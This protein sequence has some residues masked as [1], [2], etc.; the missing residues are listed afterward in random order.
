MVGQGLGAFEVRR[1]LREQ[2]GR[3]VNLFREPLMGGGVTA[4]LGRD[5]LVERNDGGV[6]LGNAIDGIAKLG[7]CP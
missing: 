3:G 5:G 6:G 4:N 1:G 7:F 2:R